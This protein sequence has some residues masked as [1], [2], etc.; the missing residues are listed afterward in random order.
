MEMR[1]V[2]VFGFSAEWAYMLGNLANCCC[3]VLPHNIVH[4]LKTLEDLGEDFGLN[5][6]LSKVDVVFGDLRER[7]ADLALEFGVRMHNEARKVR[8]RASIDD[9]LR[10]LR[11][12]FADVT[13]RRSGDTLERDFRLLDGENEE[14]NCTSINY[15]L[16]E[17]SVVASDVT[18]GL[19]ERGEM[20]Q[21]ESG[22]IEMPSAPVAQTKAKTHPS[23]RLLDRGIKF[24]EANNQSIERPRVNNGLCQL[25]G[26]LRVWEQ[27]GRDRV[28]K[29][30]VFRRR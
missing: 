7:L 26:M 11:G 22:G 29:I 25:W 6:D 28:S 12:V 10:K 20:Y 27:G 3:T 2:H 4:I 23:G 16:S 30:Q 15:C 21:D 9:S 17:F 5:H 24:F 1:T 13:E 19:Q 18:E 14:R 8:H